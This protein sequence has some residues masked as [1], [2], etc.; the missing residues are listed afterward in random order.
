MRAG[1]VGLG[2]WS[3]TVATG[4]GAG[5]LLGPV[6][7]PRCLSA[8][9]LRELSAAGSL[10]ISLAAV[11]VHTGAMLA[12]TAAIAGVV[13][14]WLGLAVLRRGW[15]NLERSWGAALAAPGLFRILL[16]RGGGTQAP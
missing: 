6:I 15:I 1:V 13:Y 4:R 2:F 7:I 5:L 14:G 10:P 11:A 12:V 16:G 9:P 8:S 3:S